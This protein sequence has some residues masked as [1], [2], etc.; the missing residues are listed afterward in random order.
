MKTDQFK[1][2]KLD[3]LQ[4]LFLLKNSNLEFKHMHHMHAFNFGEA[5]LKTNSYGMCL[6]FVD[7]FVGV[8]AIVHPIFTYK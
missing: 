4:R 1:S 3:W 6:I 8:G 2:I 5:N 7:N